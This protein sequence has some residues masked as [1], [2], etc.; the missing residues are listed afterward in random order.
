M[1]I[2]VCDV[3]IVAPSEQIAPAP[4]EAQGLPESFVALVQF[5]LELCELARARALYLLDADDE[6]RI[7][8]FDD[9]ADWIRARG[10]LPKAP[11][12]TRPDRLWPDDALEDPDFENSF[13]AYL[14]LVEPRLIAAGFYAIDANELDDDI[15]LAYVRAG[16]TGAE[17]AMV[18]YTPILDPELM[19]RF[20]ATAIDA[21]NARDETEPAGPSVEIFGVVAAGFV[22]AEAW[23]LLD[24]PGYAGDPVDASNIFVAV[25]LTS[26]D[27][28]ARRAVEGEGLVSADPGPAYDLFA[29][30]D[31]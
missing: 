1:Y 18:G 11:V 3:M 19:L 30:A 21:A 29:P 7:P 15:E 20:A 24:G 23:Q 16:R 4:Y 22:S 26:G 8:E 2:G 31:G 28:E 12:W 6:S 25:D 13:S 9:S 10:E 14:Q 17:Y 27:I 5:A